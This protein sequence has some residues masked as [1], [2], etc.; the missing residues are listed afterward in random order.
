MLFCLHI[1]V[2]SC[3]TIIIGKWAQYHERTHISS[4]AYSGVG[5]L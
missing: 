3:M 4:E 1:V 5:S 2:E